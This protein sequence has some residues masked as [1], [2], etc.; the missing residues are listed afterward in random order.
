[1]TWS[2]DWDL[3]NILCVLPQLPQPLHLTS[4]SGR[5]PKLVRHG[6]NG[7]GTRWELRWMIEEVLVGG[8]GWGWPRSPLLGW[9]WAALLLSMFSYC[10]FI[11]KGPCIYHVWVLRLFL[12]INC[13]YCFQF[14]D[15]SGKWLSWWPVIFTSSTEDAKCYGLWCSELG[16]GAPKN[17]NKHIATGS[18]PSLFF[19]YLQAT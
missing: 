9:P 8:K 7:S 10:V 6:D 5:A 3:W 15:L 1:M 12:F 2:H 17:P 19:L 18:L 11:S 14:H 16:S 13:S 4:L